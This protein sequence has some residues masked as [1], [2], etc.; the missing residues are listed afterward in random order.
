MKNSRLPETDLARFASLENEVDQEAALQKFS[1]GS[2]RWSY[3]PVRDSECGIFEA[4]TPMFPNVTGT[5]FEQVAAIIRKKCTKGLVQEE[6][7]LEV[8]KLLNEFKVSNNLKTSTFNFEPMPICH[9]H[10]VNYSSNVVFENANGLFVVFIDFR[11][12]AGISEYK[13]R[14]FVHSMQ[15]VLINQRYP[16]LEN[17]RLGI[18]RLPQLPKT[19]SDNEKRFVELKFHNTDDLFSYDELN[20]KLEKTY[21]LWEKINQKRRDQYQKPT[22]QYLGALGI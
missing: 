19:K 13:S 15:K 8:A 16:D 4:A 14:K 20:R 7:N 22:N 9:G 17:A 12:S 1:D 11:R 2:P 6:S 21:N 10:S 18:I 3:S 5:S